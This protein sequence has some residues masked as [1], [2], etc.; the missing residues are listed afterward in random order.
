MVPYNRKLWGVPLEELSL[1]WMGRFVPQPDPESIFS[2]CVAPLKT[3]QG[4]NA[5]FLYPAR[6]GIQ[7]LSDGLAGLLT[8]A[9]ELNTKVVGLDLDQRQATTADGQTIRF[10]SVVSSAPLPSIASSVLGLPEGLRVAIGK[11]RATHVSYVGLGIRSPGPRYEQKVHW[12]YFPED[13]FPF[14]R[15]GCASAAV[16]S[17]APPMAATYYV[18]FSHS[19]DKPSGLV[20]AALTGLRQCGMIHPDDPVEVAVERTLHGAYVIV[21]HA[22][23]EATSA[24][25]SWLSARGL[26]SVGRYGSWTYSSMEDALLEGKAAAQAIAQSRGTRA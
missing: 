10:S 5:S 8:Q 2:G 23:R 14:Y 20:D 19:G 9:P 17:L 22:H 13:H 12:V 4:Y 26:S 11:L 25:L 18:E 7:S 21:D 16:P 1:E 24:L 3:S 6:G 15:A